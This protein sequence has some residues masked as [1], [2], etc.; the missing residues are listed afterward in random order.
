MNLITSAWVYLYFIFVGSC[1]FWGFWTPLHFNILE[2]LSPIDVLKS[3]VY[4]ILPAVVF[5]LFM[6]A[7]D[8]YNTRTAKAMQGK[9]L[10]SDDWL[11]VKFLFCILVVGFSALFLLNAYYVVLFF[12]KLCVSPPEQRMLYAL[13]VLSIVLTIYF[14]RNPPE[15]LGDNLY[16]KN[17]VIIFFCSLPTVSYYQGSRNVDAIFDGKSSSL[18]LKSASKNCS[19]SGSGKEVYVGYYGGAYFFVNSVSRDLC[20]ERDGSVV[21][22]YKK[23]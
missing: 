23:I 5:V 16:V 9:R 7:M 19:L 14:L 4:P 1:Y 15:F 8:T 17:F 20:V 10:D 12:Y 21:L 2:Y 22:T 13:P 3:S 6:S 11:V 18:V